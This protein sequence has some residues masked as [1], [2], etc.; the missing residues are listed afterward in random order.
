MQALMLASAI[1]GGILIQVRPIMLLLIQVFMGNGQGLS[2]HSIGSMPFP[3]PN[4]PHM[5]LTLQNLLLVP[6]ITKIS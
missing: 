2:I 5:S 4:Y 6:H 1:N 3:L